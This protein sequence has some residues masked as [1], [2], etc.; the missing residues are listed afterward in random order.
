MSGRNAIPLTLSRIQEVIDYVEDNL[1]SDFGIRD[2]AE[3]AGMSHWHFQRVFRATVGETVKNYIR[4]RRLSWAAQRLLDGKENVLDIALD[5]GFDSNEA[6]TRAFRAQFG[7]SPREFRQN[8]QAPGFPQ[9][10]PQ[11][12]QVYLEHLHHNVGLAPRLDASPEIRLVGIKADLTVP[13]EAFDLIELG[14]PLWQSFLARLGEVPNR[15]GERAAL[16]CDIVSSSETE[17]RVFIMPC[18]EVGNFSDVPEGMV[19]TVRPALHNAV[20]SHAGSGSAWEYTMHYIFGAWLPC[21]GY[22]LADA[23]AFFRFAP[24]ASPF[25][26]HSA[27]EYW[28]ALKG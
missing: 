26:E 12:T 13:H 11:I 3:L 4:R 14:R 16:L 5:A 19:T 18:I 9:I 2:L 28:V 17:I 25:D 7:A 21:S 10:K 6:F 15:V 20:F 1:Q 8:R 27:L 23:P 22:V 24:Q